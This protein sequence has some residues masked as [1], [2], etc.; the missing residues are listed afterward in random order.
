MFKALTT[1]MVVDRVDVKGLER[2]TGGG[3]DR[4]SG[5]CVAPR[6]GPRGPDVPGERGMLEE[7]AR[8]LSQNGREALRRRWCFPE[9]DPLKTFT[10]SRCEMP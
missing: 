3:G 7:G 4:V 6:P 1:G 8:K 2:G 9:R 5:V 10:V